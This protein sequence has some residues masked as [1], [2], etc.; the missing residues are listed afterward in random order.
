MEKRHPRPA[1]LAA[2][3]DAV[4][5]RAALG[6]GHLLNNILLFHLSV[7]M[8]GQALGRKGQRQH[9]SSQEQQM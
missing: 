3:G 5:A 9:A 8:L 4:M 1:L 6:L 7:P 2:T